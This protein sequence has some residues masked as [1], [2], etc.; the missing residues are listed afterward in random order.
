[1]SAAFTSRSRVTGVTVTPAA[2]RALTAAA[3]HGTCGAHS[4]TFTPGRARS[5][6]PRTRAG[7]FSGTAIRSVLR[8]K[9][10][11]VPAAAPAAVT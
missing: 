10:R 8:A 4:A 5:A 6:S 9:T 11:G 1:V 2:A 3:P 7:S